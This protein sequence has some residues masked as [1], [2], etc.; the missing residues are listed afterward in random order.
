[1]P[2]RMDERGDD[3]TDVGGRENIFFGADERMKMGWIERSGGGPG[4]SWLNR[5]T[6]CSDAD[7]AVVVIITIDITSFMKRAMQ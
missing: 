5:V 7:A 6:I 3:G 1:M 2:S 4:V